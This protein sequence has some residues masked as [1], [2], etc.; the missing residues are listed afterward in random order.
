MIAICLAPSVS[1]DLKCQRE[2]VLGLGMTEKRKLSL[3]KLHIK[4]LLSFPHGIVYLHRWLT[5]GL[6][7]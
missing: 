1:D 3:D 6:F 4:T 2:K 7:S 5:S